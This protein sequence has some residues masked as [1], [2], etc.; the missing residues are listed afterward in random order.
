[1]CI[2]LC[3]RVFAGK[4]VTGCPSSLLLYLQ[5]CLTEQPNI[6]GLRALRAEFPLAQQERPVV[7]DDSCSSALVSLEL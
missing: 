6:F 5:M 7:S 1:M 4:A 2:C 3:T